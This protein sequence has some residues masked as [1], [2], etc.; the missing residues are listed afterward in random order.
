[1]GWDPSL[2]IMRLSQRGPDSIASVGSRPPRFTQSIDERSLTWCGTAGSK[3]TA[4]PRA[5][6]LHRHVT[7]AGTR[8]LRLDR[9]DPLRHEWPQQRLRSHRAPSAAGV[10]RAAPWRTEARFDAP[11]YRKAVSVWSRPGILGKVPLELRQGQ[12][13][14]LFDGLADRLGRS[15]HFFTQPR[16]REI[17]RDQAAQDRVVFLRGAVESEDAFGQAVP[18]RERLMDAQ[19]HH[20]VGAAAAHETAEGF[21]QVPW[22]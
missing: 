2:T 9:F 16:R 19:V 17:R 3:S 1:M 21:V 14:I 11:P 12:T 7:F 13:P 18:A 22:N 5:V 20:V 15:V 10:I 6:H 4:T 8:Q